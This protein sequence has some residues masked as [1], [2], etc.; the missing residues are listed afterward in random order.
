MYT[1]YFGCYDSSDRQTVENI[2][3]CLPR[4]DVTSS[5]AFVIKAVH[6]GDRNYCN[7]MIS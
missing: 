3:K 2:N 7:D 5:F 6:W 1:E 4:L